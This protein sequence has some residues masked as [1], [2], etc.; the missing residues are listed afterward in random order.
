MQP[1]TVT[2]NLI[3]AETISHFIKITPARQYRS[4]LKG[5]QLSLPAPQYS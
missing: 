5:E 4:E 3:Y 1:D 2:D